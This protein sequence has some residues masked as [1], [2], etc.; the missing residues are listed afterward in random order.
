MFR[1]RGRHKDHELDAALRPGEPVVDEDDWRIPRRLNVARD[2]VEAFA[3]DPQRRA[4]SSVDDLGIIERVTFAELARESARWSGVLGA[5]DVRPGDR[6]IVAVDHAP[7]WPAV[8]LGALK[9]GAVAVPCP[10]RL[11]D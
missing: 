1:R 6:V 11:S 8:M 5:A 3:R 7:V 10:A 9:R 2:V 4:M